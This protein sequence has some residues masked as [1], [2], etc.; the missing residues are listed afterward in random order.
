MIVV[1]KILIV[2]L[3]VVGGWVVACHLIEWIKWLWWTR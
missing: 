2:A 1:A 3:A